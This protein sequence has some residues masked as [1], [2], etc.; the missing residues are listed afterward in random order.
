MWEG[1]GAISQD[2]SSSLCRPTIW[3]F[4]QPT[5]RYI[6]NNTANPASGRAA[7]MATPGA[8]W[9]FVRVVPKAHAKKT[10]LSAHYLPP[11]TVGGCADT[12]V[13]VFDRGKVLQA[14][15]TRIRCHNA[16][17]EWVLGSGT[18]ACTG[19][20]QSAG[21]ATA[22][23]RARQEQSFVQRARALMRVQKCQS[24]KE[25]RTLHWPS[26]TFQGFEA[27]LR[28]GQPARHGDKG[29]C[30]QEAPAGSRGG[31]PGC[32]RAGRGRGHHCGA[33]DALWALGAGTADGGLR[34]KRAPAPRG[35][36]LDGQGVV[37]IRRC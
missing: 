13:C 31:G 5:T 17:G 9:A 24:L 37:Q 22:D 30:P 20:S 2:I 15:V 35:R 34:L 11:N 6:Y 28:C 14:N 32:G 4:G 27:S 33:G 36:G 26:A 7:L 8:E 21:E 1:L 12:A 18:T 3:V 25:A 16:G 23:F 19:C 29:G 10:P